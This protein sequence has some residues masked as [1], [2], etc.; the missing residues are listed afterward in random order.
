MKNKTIKLIKKNATQ[1][2]EWLLLIASI[3]VILFSVKEIVR[4][5]DIGETNSVTEKTTATQTLSPTDIVTVSPLVKE[6]ITSTQTPITVKDTIPSPESIQM[7]T[8]IADTEYISED[9]LIYSDEY[10]VKDNV[11]SKIDIQ[12]S[13]EEFKKNI[14]IAKDVT[15]KIYK[16]QQEI[17]TGYI[18]TGMKVIGSNG[19]EMTISVRGDL[20]GDGQCNQVELT[21]MI[22]HLLKLNGWVLEGY[23]TT[24][25]DISLD[26][27]VDLI[28]ISKV[29]NYIVYK[30]WDYT[31]VS[32]PDVPI[33]EVSGV[34]EGEKYVNSAKV[35]IM[36]TQNENN[37]KLIYKI[38]GAK[39]ISETEI[40]SGEEIT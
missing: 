16:G 35:K 5:E 36:T 32:T 9:D 8:S 24:S 4:A 15:I 38:S 19:Q 40:K 34:K 39:T 14:D 17:T 1:I 20:T 25:A 31:E 13:I 27:K 30:K 7:P 3:I 21:M 26:G 37:V 23:M 28:D 12:T 29:I 33:I 2:I 18:G 11:I 22:R 6:T 10:L